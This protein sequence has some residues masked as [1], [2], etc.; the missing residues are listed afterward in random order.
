MRG[1]DSLLAKLGRSFPQSV[2]R[3]LK[4]LGKV[5]G[6]ILFSRRPA[7]V[8]FFFANPLTAVVTLS[9]GH[10]PE[11]CLNSGTEEQLCRILPPSQNSGEFL[12]RPRIAKI[13]SAAR[14]HR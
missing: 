6:E 3:I 1:V 5:G 2:P 10:K 9:S 13:L 8:V 14:I 7:V 12:L 4:V 11:F